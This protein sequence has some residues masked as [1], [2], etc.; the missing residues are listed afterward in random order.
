MTTIWACLLTLSVCLSVVAGQELYFLLVGDFG[1]SPTY[2]YTTDIQTTVAKSMDAAA[3]KHNTQFVVTNGDNFYETGVASVSDSRFQYTYESVYTY[4]SLQT[5]WYIVAGNHDWEGNVTAQIAYTQRSARW[6][7]PSYYYTVTHYV[8]GTNVSVQFVFIDT[9]IYDDWFSTDSYK[10]NA[11]IK[12]T[13]AT[14]TAD[15]LIVVGHY[16]VWSVGSNGPTETLVSY[17]KPMLEQYKVS[18]YISGHDH[19]MQHLND[20]SG[21]E[22]FLNGMGAKCS[23]DRK[24]ENAVPPNSLKFFYP[25]KCDDKTN[26]GFS[27]VHATATEL[28]MHYMDAS[29]NEL[30]KAKTTNI[31]SMNEKPKRK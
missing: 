21:V 29:G 7:Y 10:E 24:N 12:Q 22:Y 4:Q 1:G 13:L 30:Y 27:V 31:R 26:G 14:S 6:Y 16:P 17:L 19:S 25:D 11:W 18:A 28:S 2:P 20:G 15:W 3:K 23:H 9:I 8:P 5:R